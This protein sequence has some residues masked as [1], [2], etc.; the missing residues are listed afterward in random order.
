MKKQLR[1]GIIGCS[2]ISNKS[3]IPAILKATN[4]ELCGIGSR[5]T[6][7]AKKFSNI[8]GC[9]NYGTYEDVIED[10]KIDAVYISTPVSKHEEWILKAASAGKHILCEKSLT[11]SFSSAKTI[12]KSCK[13]NN[14]RIME[15]FMYRF[16]PSH[17]K[18]KELI[19]TGKIGKP[20][21]FS[22]RY[23]FPPISKEDIRY[24]RTLGGG[25]LNDA[26]CYPIHAPRMLFQS[27][28]E[29]ILCELT[30]D[31]EKQVDTKA[32]ILMKFEDDI[33]S[34][35]S[36]GYDMFY[37]STYSIWGSEGF[38]SLSRS[39]NVPPDMHA[40][41]DIE[42]KDS[43]DSISLELVDHFQLMIET[44]CNE[45]QGSSLSNY[46]FEEDLFNQAKVM[47]AARIS[48]NEKRYV[49]IDEVK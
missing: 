25:I 13:D 32:N 17:M 27:E 22:S 39:Y 37:Q 31:E 40:I 16:H 8:F 34:H 21:T 11:D 7:K 1:L 38:L 9:N 14:V 10:E 6:E 45:I 30:M 41:L 24:D 18:V 44:F 12:L 46:N 47:Q 15:G 4:G 48:N 42:S 49:K 26:G 5:S 3:T 23:G 33:Y 19:K 20:Y 35:S 43:K 28:P 36:V 29:G 2:N